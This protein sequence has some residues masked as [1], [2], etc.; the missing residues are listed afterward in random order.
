ME[1]AQKALKD[2]FGYDEFRPLQSEI[3]QS[4]LEGKDILAL[5]PTGGGKSICYQIPALVSEGLAL[6]LSPL[7]ALM[8]DQVESLRSNG[9]QADFLNSSLAY[10]EVR[11][12]EGDLLAGRT[13][14][15]YVSPE[16]LL[17][18]SFQPLLR[19]LKLS[20]IAIDEAHC[21]SSWGHDFR[22]EYTQLRFLRDQFPNLPIIALTAT[23][24]KTT[25]EDIAV[26]LNLR[27]PQVFVAS[28]DRPNIF[29]RVAPGQ[30]RLQQILQFVRKRPGQSGI[31]Y[32]L[33]RKTCVDLAKTLV[34]QGIKAAPYHA[35]LEPALR[36]QVQEDF[37]ND[38]TQIV[39]ATIAFGMGIDKSNVRY[40]IHY[41]MP[42]N[43]E[44]YYQEIGR[45]GRDGLPADALMFFSF[46]DVNTYRDML[47]KGEGSEEIKRL[48]FAKLDRM[49][50]FAQTPVCRRRMVLV[51]FGEQHPGNCGACDVCEH[52]PE[53]FDGT[54]EAQK[55]L[56]AIKRAEEKAG[57]N[58][59]ID[60]LRGSR[61][62]E[63]FR[64]GYHKLKTYGVGQEHNFEAWR[65]FIGQI[66]QMGLAEVVF[67][68]G[69]RLRVTEAGKAVLYQKQKVAL[70]SH[71]PKPKPEKVAEEPRHAATRD[72]ELFDELALL[73]KAMA[74]DLGLPP[75]VIFSDATLEVMTRRYPTTDQEM[76][77]ISGVGQFKLEKF[78]QPFMEAIAAYMRRKN[79]EKPI[80]EAP[81]EVKMSRAKNEGELSSPQIS[82][83][84]FNQ[85]LGPDEIAERRTLKVSTIWSHLIEEYQNGAD[86]DIG[87][88]L[89][90]EDID[91]IGGAL[92]L[93]ESTPDLKPIY[94]H[95]K[96]HFSYEALRFALAY[97]S[98]KRG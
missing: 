35:E 98:R 4:V 25:R 56:S 67:A 30:K 20:F 84:M 39:C 6:V 52:P 92:P 83:S 71:T 40:V 75:Y 68:E 64:R 13:K 60:I 58:L 28:F 47:D 27:D 57:I 97:I 7:I 38:R 2:V 24:D 96:G 86:L 22:P 72:Q 78:A 50:E 1:R 33:A 70:A 49:Y 85:G 46:A 61:S 63:V 34:Q 11:R 95:F 94:E 32:S 62:S 5:M 73:R 51:Y 69:N 77:A 74:R 66:I 90:P 87:R 76:L 81:V 14:L 3:V 59:I 54:I 31:I 9:V 26:Q 91:L 42:R 18:Q 37:I 79:I 88:I 55:A 82:L 16:K 93:F 80:F 65:F 53:Y 89:S 17:S 29:L 10:S 36:N 15:L 43:V 41:N 23:A 45:A 19:S 21:I 44:S 8:K 12:V 48:K